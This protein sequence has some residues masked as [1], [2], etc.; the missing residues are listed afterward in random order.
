MEDEETENVA[1]ED[2][3]YDALTSQYQEYVKEFQDKPRH[4]WTDE[5]KLLFI[6]RLRFQVRMNHTKTMQSISV[7]FYLKF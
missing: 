5:Q 4:T 6:K 1:E 7:R 2:I 3:D